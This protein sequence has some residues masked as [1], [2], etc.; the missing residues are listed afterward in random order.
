MEKRVKIFPKMLNLHSES[1]YFCIW[2]KTPYELFRLIR[3]KQNNAMCAKQDHMISEKSNIHVFIVVYMFFLLQST[4]PLLPG[5][6]NPLHL[7]RKIL[8]ISTSRESDYNSVMYCTSSENATRLL[9]R[10]QAG[11]LSDSLC[12]EQ[13]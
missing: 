3:N 13:Q 8:Q 12:S 7:L 9:S 6:L 4:I 10:L 1:E 11:L 5:S 2:K